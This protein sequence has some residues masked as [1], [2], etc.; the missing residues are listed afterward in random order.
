MKRTL[1][2][3]VMLSAGCLGGPETVLEESGGEALDAPEGCR[4][5]VEVVVWDAQQWMRLGQQFAAHPT[6]CAEYYLSVPGIADHKTTLRRGAAEDIRALG[7][8]FH[9]MAEFHWG[10]WH[11][12]VEQGG[13]TWAEAGREFRRRMAEAG[14]DVAAGDTWAINELPSS[15]RKNTP[16]A[17]THARNLV[18]ALHEGNPGDDLA[19]GAAFIVG[20]GQEMVNYS[21]YKPQLEDWLCDADF[22]VDMNVAVRWWGQEV[23]ANPQ[24]SCF[25]GVTGARSEAINEFIQH[26]PRLAAAGPSCAATARSYLSRAY[27]PLV[28]AAWKSDVGYGDTRITLD[29]MKHH[30]STEIYATRAWAGDHRYPDGRV[31]LAWAPHNLDEDP[32]EVFAGKLDE[33]AQR[34][35][36]AIQGAYGPGDSRARHACSP[37]GAYTWCQCRVDGARRNTAWPSL[38]GRW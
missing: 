25:D 6:P 7:P 14:Y 5:P 11:E 28:G 4:W 1:I 2:G 17:R 18:R 20:V 32:P 15:M 13:H 19:R 21:F 29:Q 22:W 8:Q 26:F 35:A 3:L 23:Y 38:F 9:A 37:S 27:V 36:V 24:R 12:W 33:L 10:A 30:V 34:I 16:G 31:G